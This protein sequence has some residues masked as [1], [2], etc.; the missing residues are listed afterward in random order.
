LLTMLSI[1]NKS[2]VR[3]NILACGGTGG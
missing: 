3:P 1:F 2:M